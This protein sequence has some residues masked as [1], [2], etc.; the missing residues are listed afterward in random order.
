M[1]PS[2]HIMVDA[3]TTAPPIVVPESPA[4]PPPT[5]ARSSRGVWASLVFHALILAALAWHAWPRDDTPP[6]PPISVDLVEIGPST[7][8]PAAARH[9]DVPQERAEEISDRASRDAVPPKAPEP[10]TA[11]QTASATAASAGQKA[12][13][14]SVPV[15]KTVAPAAPS[16]PLSQRLQ[17]LAKLAEPNTKLVPDPSTQSGAGRSNVTASN[18]TATGP[19]EYGIKDFIRAQV[20]RRWYVADQT[21]VSKGWTVTIHMKLKR[22]GTVTLA[23]VVDMARYKTNRQYIDFALSARNA[24]L[25]SSPLAIPPGGYEYAKELV[26][27]FD[28]RAVLQ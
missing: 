20:M 2:F 22:D 10:A 11:H 27:E 14:K 8:S 13:T 15:S 9:A 7:Q 4:A 24:V 16:D 12:S 19:A 6:V 3:G 25:L 23:E 21:P 5:E 28:P 18:G 1:H 17:Q 26:L